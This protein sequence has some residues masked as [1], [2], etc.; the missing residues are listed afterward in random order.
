[1]LGCFERRGCVAAGVCEDAF[2]DFVPL[3]VV[4]SDN[5]MDAVLDHV[6]PDA[7]LVSLDVHGN[8]CY[9]NR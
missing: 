3:D 1:M 4:T 7:S 6:I 9:T 8:R 5:R 2:F